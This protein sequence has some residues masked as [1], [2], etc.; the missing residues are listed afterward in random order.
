MAAKDFSKIL[1][2]FGTGLKSGINVVHRTPKDIADEKKAR[3]T[4]EDLMEFFEDQK[5]NP[6]VSVSTL[7]AKQAELREI[8][9]VVKQY[10]AAAETEKLRLAPVPETKLG[11]AGRVIGEQGKAFAEG[12]MGTGPAFVNA[13]RE[14]LF[15]EKDDREDRKSRREP[16]E[17][18][19][20][21]KDQSA[22][23]KLVRSSGGTVAKTDD[24]SLKSFRDDLFK[25]LKII[26]GFLKPKESLTKQLTGQEAAPTQAADA[27]GSLVGDLAGAAGDLLGGRGKAATTGG[28][29]AKG[30][31]KAAG[32]GGTFIGKAAR[33]MGGK[34]GMIG[35]GVLGAIGGGI[36]AYDRISEASNTEAATKEQVQADLAAGK[37]SE[38]QAQQQLTAASDKAT[39]SK[40]AGAGEGLGIFGGGLAGAKAGAMIGTAF[41]G[42]I[43]TIAGGLIGGAVGAFGGSKLGSYLGEKVGGLFTSSESKD[44]GKID[45]KDRGSFE[46]NVNGKTISGSWDASTKTYRL[47]NEPSTK[48][49]VEAARKELGLGAGSKIS[50]SNLLTAGPAGIM[51][52]NLSTASLSPQGTPQSGNLMQNLSLQNK[53][54]A[55][56][57]AAPTVVNNI[58]NNNMGSGGQSSTVIPLKPGVRPESSSLTRY[59][60]RVAVY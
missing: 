6:T 49:A 11:T 44:D 18:D 45:G 23:E 32:T 60:D 52:N 34:G 28:T 35:A 2:A 22:L 55:A 7:K 54:M 15:G 50:S 19:S 31:A 38:Q 1:G 59:L 58:T 24:I 16:T 25:E 40:A 47:N 9:E 29:V 14:T 48:E 5:K 36:V 43:G 39:V 4:L 26:Q 21:K 37:I 10:D 51:K 56:T 46:G 53:E 57:P 41:G 17:F 30:A 33:F 42:P 13:I 12:F 3:E 8:G 27:G 20:Y